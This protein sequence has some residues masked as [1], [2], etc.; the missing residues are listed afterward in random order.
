MIAID[1]D[2]RGALAELLLGIADDEFVI[3]LD[4]DPTQLDREEEL[5]PGRDAG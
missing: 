4:S 3:G 1:V 5:D 2:A